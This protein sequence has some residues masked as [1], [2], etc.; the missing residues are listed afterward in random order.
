MPHQIAPQR[1]HGA[2]DQDR[3]LGRLLREADPR[4]VDLLHLAGQAGL[5]Q[6]QPVGAERVGL[7][8]IDPR[9][10]VAAVNLL[11]EVRVG[12]VQLVEAAVEEDSMLVQHRPHG[13]VANEDLL[14]DKLVKSGSFHAIGLPKQAERSSC[15]IRF[16][17]CET[18]QHSDKAISMQ[19]ILIASRRDRRPDKIVATG[20]P[21][22][23]TPSPRRN[24]PYC[25]D[26]A[27]D[28]KIGN[29]V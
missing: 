22:R 24:P 3:A 25:H 27:L 8:E 16:I 12:Q 15:R 1:P 9:L 6:F 23:P 21:R 14:A 5:R 4:P 13:A 17:N 26:L 10:D 11:D 20:A 7:D 29:S 28:S 18:T 2:G 19:A